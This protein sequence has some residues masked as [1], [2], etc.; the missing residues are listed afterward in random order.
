M[1]CA[2]AGDGLAFDDRVF[3]RWLVTILIPPRA[4]PA[5]IP[6]RMRPMVRKSGLGRAGLGWVGLGL[7]YRCSE[8]SRRCSRCV[9]SKWEGVQSPAQVFR[10]E[11]GGWV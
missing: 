7:S 11:C 8:L 2:G 4:A 10:C 5:V 3:S 1:P 9:G 6:V